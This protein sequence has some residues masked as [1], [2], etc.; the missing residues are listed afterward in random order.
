MQVLLI[1]LVLA[2]IATMLLRVT[3]S[4]T[5]SAR[6]TRRAASAEVLIQACMAEV[7]SLWSQKTPDAFRTDM[8]GKN[9]KPCMYHK[10]NTCMH[11]YECKYT[12]EDREY[13]VTAT[14][15][16]PSTN[17]YKLEYE[18]NKETTDYL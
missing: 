17:T 16:K 1:A 14:F 18:I 5:S 13:A 10:G 9:G 3:L 4:R 6:Q 2:G 15:T 12:I 7:N 11:N 8:Q